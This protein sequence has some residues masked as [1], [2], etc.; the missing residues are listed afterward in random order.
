M[1]PDVERLLNGILE[2]DRLSLSRAITLIET[3]LPDHFPFR[4]ELI[5]KVE[6][7]AGNSLRLAITGVPGAGKSTLIDRLG[8]HWAEAG[9]KVAVLAIDPSS[10]ISQGSILGDKTRMTDL[11]RHPNAF[12]RPSPTRLQLGGI[13]PNTFETILLCEAAGFDR[14]IVET[15]GVGQS[16]TLASSLTDI[17]LLLLVTGTGDDLQGV[18]KG[19]LETADLVLVNK[20]DGANEDRARAFSRELK[21]ISSL[22]PLRGNGRHA[23]ILQGSAQKPEMLQ[24]LEQELAQ[25]DADIRENGRFQTQRRAQ[26][27]SWLRSLVRRHLEEKIQY[28]PD[29][30]RA[31]N[32]A[33][34]AVRQG[35]PVSQEAAQV[36]ERGKFVF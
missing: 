5:R 6:P 7:L 19:I 20:A 24:V 18:K 21:Q 29:W 15:V 16:E 26:N 31:M 9:H 4:D 34:E 22:W 8:L 36:W 32:Q 14:I 30:T 11:S 27:Q 13:A 10:H 35:N 3:E 17:C 1:R 23:R 33:A 2:G 25:F 12:I 28:H